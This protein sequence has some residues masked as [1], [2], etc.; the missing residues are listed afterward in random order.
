M[1]FLHTNRVNF[2]V[3][4]QHFFHDSHD[5]I[6]LR[7]NGSIVIVVV[8][9][10]IRIG[11]MRKLKCQF[12][13]VFP[14]NFVELALPPFSVIKN[15]FVNNVPSVNATSVTRY[16]GFDMVPHALYK[17]L[18]GNI[19]SVHIH[20]KPFRSLR[21]PNERMPDDFHA[22]FFTEFDEAISLSEIK[23]TLPGLQ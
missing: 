22:V 14:D 3:S 2:A 21:M 13:K 1:M 4:I 19:L 20:E 15:G 11:L 12:E 10:G 9:L 23:F 17:H 18:S 16:D 5:A 8:E 7:R 6:S